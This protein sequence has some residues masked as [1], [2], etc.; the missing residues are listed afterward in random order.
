MSPNMSEEDQTQTA[1]P[2]VMSPKAPAPGLSAAQ[3][4]AILAA[5]LVLVAALDLFFFTGF[6]GSDDIEYL[7]AARAVFND[8]QF[9][10]RADFGAERLTLLGVECARRHVVRF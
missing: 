6:Y 10:S 4:A 2:A 1:K 3:T 8:G 7:T 9:N 5:I